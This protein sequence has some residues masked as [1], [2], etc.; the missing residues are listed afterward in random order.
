MDFN[1]KLNSIIEKNDSLVCVGLDI[2]K[3]KM[4]GF[5]F[6]EI[7][8]PFLFFNKQIIDKTKDLVC[9]YKLNMAFYEVLGLDG[10]RVLKE[11]I[12][13]I[14]DDLIVILDGKRND[15]GNTARMYARSLFETLSADAATINPFFGIDGVKPFLS[16]KD[17]CSFILCRTS[18]KSA[19]EL[20]DLKIGEDPLYVVVS[21]KIDEWNKYGNTGVVVGATYPEE[22]KKIRSILGDNVPFLIPGVGKQ[23]GNVKKTIKYGTDKNGGMAI[24]NSSRG[25]IYAGDDTGFA[26]KSREKTVFLKDLINKYR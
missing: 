2:D 7:D 9:G 19:V 6:D 12:A 14:P 1:E 11:T 22:L 8:S 3:D 17:K 20:Q 18:N 15:I 23:G 16:Y 21:K 24:I 5:I 13:Y 26:D 25:I 4:P 10:L